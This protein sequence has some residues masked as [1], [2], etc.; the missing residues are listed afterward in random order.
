M[1]L[2]TYSLYIECGLYIYLLRLLE[3]PRKSNQFRSLVDFKLHVEFHSFL[4][5]YSTTKN[6]RY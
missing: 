6:Y 1:G 4:I 3:G 2:F 5:M